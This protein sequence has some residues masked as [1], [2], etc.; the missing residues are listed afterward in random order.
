MEF[1]EVFFHSVILGRNGRHEPDCQETRRNPAR[2]RGGCR[3]DPARA[4]R[5]CAIRQAGRREFSAAVRKE[6]ALVG[7]R[8]CEGGACWGNDLSVQELAS[9]NLEL[10]QVK[11]RWANEREEGRKTSQTEASGNLLRLRNA[12][13]MSTMRPTEA[14]SLKG[15][16]KQLEVDNLTLAAETAR[17][18]SDM[19]EL[20]NKLRTVPL[21][22]T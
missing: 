13:A 3:L 16:V 1:L 2:P 6:G 5:L 20:R 4:F 21:H 17:Y 10:E 12:N 9:K 19:E 22:F 14:D 11:S 7:A 18:K 15:Q 8:S